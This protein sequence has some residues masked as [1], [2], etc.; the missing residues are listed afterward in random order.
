MAHLQQS[1]AR[2]WPTNTERMKGSNLLFRAETITFKYP[3]SLDYGNVHKYIDI[4]VG[5]Q[6]A[7]GFVTYMHYSYIR[8][9][10]LNPQTAR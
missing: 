6:R 7:A 9:Y 5:S 8:V 2:L 10:H 4:A 1:T 3:I